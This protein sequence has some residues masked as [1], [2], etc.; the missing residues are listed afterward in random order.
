M[1]GGF[2]TSMNRSMTGKAA[3]IIRIGA[4][5][6]LAVVIAVGIAAYFAQPSFISWHTRAVASWDLSVLIYLGLGYFRLIAGG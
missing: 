4:M 6:R 2:A 1:R 3:W 5:Q